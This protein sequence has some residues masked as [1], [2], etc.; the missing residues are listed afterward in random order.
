MILIVIG[1]Y[2]FTSILVY[3]SI[4]RMHSESHST[5]PIAIASRPIVGRIDSI[6]LLLAYASESGIDRYRSFNIDIY[7]A[8]CMAG[9]VRTY[10]CIYMYGYTYI[11]SIVCIYIFTGPGFSLNLTL[12]GVNLINLNSIVAGGRGP[13]E[14]LL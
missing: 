12:H 2:A 4:L 7:I 3:Y 13:F 11:Y 10:V 1:A 14:N 9:Y 6:Q 5:W 8:I